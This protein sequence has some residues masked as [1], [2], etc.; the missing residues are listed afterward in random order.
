MY[1]VSTFNV[2]FIRLTDDH[3]GA[4]FTYGLLYSSLIKIVV[5]IDEGLEDE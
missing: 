1:V 3:I 5:R 2:N 4:L